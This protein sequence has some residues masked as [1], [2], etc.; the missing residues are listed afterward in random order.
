[1]KTAV[2]VPDEVFEQAERLARRMKKSRS[3]LF[4]HALEE[5]VAR[6]AP[7]QVTEAMDAVCAEIDSE[8]DP[9]IAAASR[10]TLERSEW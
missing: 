2:S 8:P 7:D 10:R 9:F 4:R 5:Y 6:H 1:M 3:Q